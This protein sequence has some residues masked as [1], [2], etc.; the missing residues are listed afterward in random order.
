MGLHRTSKEPPTCPAQWMM[1]QGDT[2]T[3]HNPRGSV[4]GDCDNPLGGSWMKVGKCSV[5]I[6]ILVGMTPREII[7]REPPTCPA[8]WIMDQ[9]DTQTY[10]NPRGRVV[11]E[12]RKA[13]C[14]YRDFGGHDTEGGCLSD[15]FC[16]TTKPYLKT[17]GTSK[18]WCLRWCW[19]VTALSLCK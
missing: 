2:R 17:V 19:G 14:L 1:G 10:H 8:R 11:D 13:L 9:G 15:G 7:L 6:G 16:S 3:Y 4:E 12:G 18:N 5:Y